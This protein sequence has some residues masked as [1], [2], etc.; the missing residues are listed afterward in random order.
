M[1]E[2]EAAAAVF[3]ATTTT[4]D[5]VRSEAPS[6]TSP[7]DVD[8]HRRPSTSHCRTT[9]TDRRR[10][11]LETDQDLV[12]ADRYRL[13]AEVVIT[14]IAVLQATFEVQAQVVRPQV[15]SEVLQVT[16][17]VRAQVTVL[18]LTATIEVEAHHATT[19][20]STAHLLAQ[21]VL[22]AVAVEARH[23]VAQDPVPAALLAEDRCPET[24]VLLAMVASVQRMDEAE[25]EAE[26]EA[27]HAIMVALLVQVV[28]EARLAILA[29]LGALRATMVVTEA[30]LVDLRAQDDQAVLRATTATRAARRALVGLAQKVLYAMALVARE[31][32]N[33]I[34]TE[35]SH[36]HTTWTTVAHPLRTTTWATAAHH[37]TTW[38]TT[39]HHS[40]T[41]TTAAH[42]HR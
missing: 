20:R 5:L 7:R 38:T 35:A 24:A 37:S 3:R 19:V 17:V 26:A 18:R 31:A 15:V 2:D 33:A 27:H 21:E 11:A 14:S 4:T 40:T 10:L 16:S 1:D 30:H 29:V 41:W 13:T 6:R 9:T 22:V 36:P 8:H 28:M 12:D 34:A 23:V 39:A 42:L 32:L 25:A